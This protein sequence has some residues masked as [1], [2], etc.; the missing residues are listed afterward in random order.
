VL[1]HEYTHVVTLGL[2]HNKMPRW[3]SE[4]ISVFEEGRRDRAWG[5]PMTP[6]FRELILAG[7]LAPVGRLSGA[8]L[9]PKDGEHLMFAYFQS[10]LVVEW[11]VERFGFDA[12]KAILRD[13]GQ[14]VEI[15]R[16]LAAHT[17]PLG[18]LEKEFEAFARERARAFAP[19]ADWSKPEAA[20]LAKPEPQA[21]QRW[22]DKHPGSVWALYRQAQALIDAQKW[23]E[24]KAPLERLIALDPEQR[25]ADNAYLL[26][27][28]AH[29]KLDETAEER[30]VLD[31]VA[32]LSSDAQVAFLRSMELA[33]A[34]GDWQAAAVSAE[35]VLAVRPMT[36]N[37]YRSLGR[38]L[39]E[40]GATDKQA[41]EG[42]VA[43]FRNVL[44][45]EPADPA[46]VHLRLARLLRRRD[47][48]AARRHVVDALAEAPRFR[49][50][51]RL[52]LELHGEA[53]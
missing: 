42:A 15:N 43:A 14:G 2:T 6:R 29:R 32:A 45:L 1:W 22:L 17:A 3:L 52:L 21:V 53:R 27:A 51:Q 28:L 50:A 48:K 9:S 47:P 4:G 37:A 33:A 34:A 41:A 10:A 30:K 13:L 8:F 35:R 5:Q 11:L 18:T 7:E 44:R 24:A 12:L 31:R 16:A 26:L 38:A 25:G 20:L 40:R 23:R 49:E 19:K 36:A 46:D 39:E